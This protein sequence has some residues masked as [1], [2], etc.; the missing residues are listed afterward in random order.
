LSRFK[1]KSAASSGNFPVTVRVTDNGSP[2]LNDFE[3]RGS[4]EDGIARL[5]LAD[6]KLHL[7]FLGFSDI[8]GIG[9]YK[10]EA[11]VPESL[12]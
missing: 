2:A 8:W 3:A 5:V 1:A 12:Q 11:V 6:F 4:C 9:N 10:V 7:V